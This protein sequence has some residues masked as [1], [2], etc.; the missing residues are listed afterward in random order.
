M[1]SES[2][3]RAIAR[4]YVERNRRY[5][6]LPPCRAILNL[7][8]GSGSFLKNY[9]WPSLIINVDRGD[10]IAG[11][12]AYGVKHKGFSG[13]VALNPDGRCV[14]L[15]ANIMEALPRFQSGIFDMVVAGQLIEHL[16][17]RDLEVLLHECGRVLA[18]DGFLQID[19]VTERLGEDTEG[20]EQHFTAES[21]GVLLEHMGFEKLELTEFAGGTAVWALYRRT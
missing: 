1:N 17:T 13:F 3:Q 20:H 16:S 21:L 10:A 7:G 8:S 6:K 5:E 15:Q 18:T 12:P 19:T 9:P 4:L 14:N 11:Y 2:A